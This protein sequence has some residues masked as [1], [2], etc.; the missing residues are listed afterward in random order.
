MR[1]KLINIVL[2]LIVAFVVGLLS[3]HITFKLLSF[4]KTVTV[5]DLK[6][7]GI[8][9]ANEILR[10]NNLYLRVEGEDYDPYM[11]EGF[12]LRQDVPPG[13]SVKE[14]REIRVVLSKGPRIRYVPDVV[15]QP[16]EEAKN[17]LYERGIKITKIIYV[18]SKSVP[19]D[20]V[21]AQRP[22]SDEIAGE[23]FKIIVS[24]GE[25]EEEIK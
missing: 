5:P 10:K 17:I 7:K 25:F 15:G 1:N 6:G 12:I 23:E 11:P 2:Y 3:G 14:S 8:I 24:L 4:S 16:V 21:I 20:V 9:E 22:E 13:S 18:H 19:K